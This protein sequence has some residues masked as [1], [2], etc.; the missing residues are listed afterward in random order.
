MLEQC[1]LE[2]DAGAV[3][4]FKN[5]DYLLTTDNKVKRCP[6]DGS[7]TCVTVAGQGAGVSKRWL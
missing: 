4:V 6:G 3:A 2:N 7:G 5:G 1:D